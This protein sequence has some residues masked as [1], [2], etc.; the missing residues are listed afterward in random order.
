[1]ALQS[2]HNQKVHVT[3]R[4]TQFTTKVK[5]G[6]SDGLMLG[7]LA[8]ALS[9]SALLQ[10]RHAFAISWFSLKTDLTIY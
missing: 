3:F 5:M 1:M 9:V 8:H 7:R 2:T 6:R 10:P 4:G